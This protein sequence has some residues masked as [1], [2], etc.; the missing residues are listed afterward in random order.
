MVNASK[1]LISEYEKQKKTPSDQ[2]IAQ[3]LESNLFEW[4]FTLKGCPSSPYEGGLYHGKVELPQEYPMAG[5]DIIFL[6]ENGRFET[7]KKICL[8]NTSYHPESWTPLWTIRMMIESLET[9]FTEDAAGIGALKHSDEQRKKLAKE[10]LVF[11]CAT[12]GKMN[13]HREFL[14]K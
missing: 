9:F 3:P 5:P 10:S 6:T 12:C 7:G 13:E 4:H 14:L 2:F 11:E 8:S 1:R